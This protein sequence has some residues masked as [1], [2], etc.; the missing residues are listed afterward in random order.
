MRG[1]HGRRRGG[2]GQKLLNIRLGQ[3]TAGREFRADEVFV[4]NVWV[5]VELALLVMINFLAG[6]VI[7]DRLMPVLIVA[8]KKTPPIRSVIETPNFVRAGPV[9]RFLGISGSPEER[10]FR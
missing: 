10:G 3:R 4:G 7:G 6:N 1:E 9:E 2:G 5:S 8:E